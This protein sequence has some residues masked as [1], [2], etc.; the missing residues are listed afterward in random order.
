MAAYTIIAAC[1]VGTF[2]LSACTFRLLYT[3]RPGQCK[4]QQTM[5]PH[6]MLPYSSYPSLRSINHLQSDDI[7]Q[8]ALLA[9]VTGPASGMSVQRTAPSF[10]RLTQPVSTMSI[11]SLGARLSQ[12]MVCHW[13]LT[14][15]SCA[16]LTHF[17][18]VPTDR[19]PSRLCQRRIGPPRRIA[20]RA[21]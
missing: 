8:S 3:S 14:M 18:R 9:G 16:V 7:S 10:G 4:C 2:V 21:S 6:D 19:I 13:L 12:M 17:G 20:Q 1:S 15:V 5:S 11:R